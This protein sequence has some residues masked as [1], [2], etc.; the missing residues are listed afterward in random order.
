MER[1][2]FCFPYR[3]VGGVPVL[4]SR[5]AAEI[6]RRGGHEVHVV[7]YQDGTMAGARSAG[8][9]L[10][11]FTDDSGATVPEESTLLFQTTR[12]W[13]LYPEL[14]VPPGTRL[15]FWNCHPFNLVPTPP[16][17]RAL[18]TG[19]QTLGRATL[20][21]LMRPYR[22]T[23]V[24]FTRF[25][26]EHRALAFMDQ[27]NVDATEGYL[28]I[29]IPAP[30]YL[31]VC[32]GSALPKPSPRTL[33][34]PLRLAW[35][36]RIADFKH[37]ILSRALMDLDRVQPKLAVALSFTI[38][39]EGPFRESVE[40]TVAGL[41]NLKV[42][43][44]GELPAGRLADFLREDVDVLFAMGTSALEG[45][46]AGIPTVLLDVSYRPVL[47]GY[48]YTWLHERAGYTLGD[49]ISPKF[50][51]PGNNSLE[52]LIKSAM[53][54]HSDLALAAW[55]HYNR[56]HGLGSVTDRLLTLAFASTCLRWDFEA[57]GFDRPDPFYGALRRLRAMM[58]K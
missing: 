24:R 35:I 34:S 21:T 38:V 40:R 7:D 19:N 55:G 20:A 6:A 9:E 45:I 22:N 30:T 43:F 31:P 5:I 44:S 29:G 49:M 25:L 50:I 47:Q 51:E 3:G 13:A 10:I 42:R 37:H 2:V 58:S 41:K 39:G 16:G 4:F 57:A 15:F 26:L 56:H 46:R 27:A 28:G 11:R 18:V 1:L 23:M 36:G 53:D 54:N 33:Q 14:R 8:V 12:P 48:R 17:L 52:K 32:A